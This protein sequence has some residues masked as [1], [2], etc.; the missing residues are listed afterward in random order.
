MY[1]GY[2]YR[3]WLIND[4]EIEKSYIGQVYNRTPEQRW[5]K[6][7]K[8][9][10]PQK[11][12]EPTKF[13]NAIK[14]YGWNNFI[15]E[16]LL[17]IE[18]ETEEELCFWLDEW[19]KY[20][21]EKYDSFYN[22]YNSTTGGS[23]GIMSEETKRRMS[24]ARK[25]KP[26]SEQHKQHIGEAMTGMVFSKERNLKI[27]S[28]LKGKPHSEERKK[29]ISNSKKGKPSTFKGKH[30]P[31]DAKQ[32]ISDSLKG[33]KLSEET[34][35]KLSENSFNA[36]KV[37]C[38]ETLQ[39]FDTIDKALKWCNIK[40]GISKCCKDNTKS[41]GKHPITKEPLHW[42]YYEDYL[43]LQ[44]EQQNNDNLDSTTNVA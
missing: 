27:S 23:N 20:Y 35:A 22:G 39:I 21:I 16:I 3:H 13:Y 42:M 32:R 43:K 24:E 26:L 33:R 10:K 38:L 12:N 18:C 41:A 17:V 44:E 1:V 31:E 36:T 15:H 19:E 14:K 4:K 6:D 11:N 25:G 8:G 7:G 2:I 5:K 34:K 40:S 29:N 9:Y 30:Q 37:I 28:T